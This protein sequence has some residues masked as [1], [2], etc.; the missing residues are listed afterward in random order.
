VRRLFLAIAI[1]LTVLFGS[2]FGQTTGRELY[3]AKCAACHT[4]DGS[5][6]EE[7][8]MVI[9]QGKGKMPAYA[10]KFNREQIQMLVNYIRELGQRH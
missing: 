10:K 2:A 7:L 9:S 3:V 1:S 5:G 4:L 8:S 6:S